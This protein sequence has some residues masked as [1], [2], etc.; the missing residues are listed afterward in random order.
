MLG[1]NDAIAS[2]GW[3]TVGTNLTTLI[4]AEQVSG[5]AVLLT[6]PPTSISSGVTA[7]L[8]TYEPG[9]QTLARTLNIPI[10]D[11]YARWGSTYQGVKWTV[12]GTHPTVAGYQDIAG[13]LW[14]LIST[15]Q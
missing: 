7:L 12:D 6:P 5:D 3:S 14:A 8:A 13:A 11:I 4:T 15:I 1:V 10:V 9:Y 2:T